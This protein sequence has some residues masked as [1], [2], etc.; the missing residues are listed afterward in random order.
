[1][2]EKKSKYYLQRKPSGFLGNSP[3]WWGKNGKGYTAYI[4]GAE[5]FTEEDAKKKVDENPEKWAMYACDEA[6]VKL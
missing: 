1:M 6:E 2:S 4:S 5:R 3:I